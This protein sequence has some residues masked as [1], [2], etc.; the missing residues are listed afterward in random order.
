MS[1]MSELH[2]LLETFSH[3]G[4]RVPRHMHEGIV[5]YIESGRPV[6]DFLRSV[7]ENDLRGACAHADDFNIRNI[8]ATVAFLYNYAPSECWGD[9]AK[10]S[11]WVRR[12]SEERRRKELS[13]HNL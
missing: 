3:S 5:A 13:A 6:G 10:V 8:P 4:M 7:L 2:L 9:P 11:A 1:A 12:H